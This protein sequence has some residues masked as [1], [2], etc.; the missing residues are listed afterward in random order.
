MQ[1]KKASLTISVKETNMMQVAQMTTDID[2]PGK[3]CDGNTGCACFIE[4]LKSTT[5]QW[6]QI[7]ELKFFSLFENCCCFNRL[8]IIKMW[9]L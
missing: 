8:I 1:I 7:I 6:C 2:V 4:L 5:H 9:R 3:D